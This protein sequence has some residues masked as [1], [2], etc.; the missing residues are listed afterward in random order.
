MRYWY[1]HIWIPARPTELKHCAKILFVIWG[2]ERLKK[3][4]IYLC[5]MAE[6]SDTNCIVFNILVI[7]KLNHRNQDQNDI[8]LMKNTKTY[9]FCKV[10]LRSP[11]SAFLTRLKLG[12]TTMLIQNHH[13]TEG[14]TQGSSAG[15]RGFSGAWP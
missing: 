11:I 9:F 5:E 8:V 1:T 4:W 2:W 7:H 15:Q 12:K 3:I 6:K 14:R 13:Y 10:L